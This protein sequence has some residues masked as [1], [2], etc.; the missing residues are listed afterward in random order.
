MTVQKNRSLVTIFGE[1]VESRIVPVDR[2]PHG[3]DQRE[4]MIDHMNTAPRWRKRRNHGDRRP[5]QRLKIPYKGA[6]V[7]SEHADVLEV[8][9]KGSESGWVCRA[10][11]VEQGHVCPIN[12]ENALCIGPPNG[13]FQN[14]RITQQCDVGVG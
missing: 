4:R 12:G 14:P 6:I 10:L 2:K 1:K 8:L 9:E 13:D 5:A 7:A 3:S 11:L